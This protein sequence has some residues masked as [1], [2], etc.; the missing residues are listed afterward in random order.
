MPGT[1]AELEGVN[2]LLRAL[3]RAGGPGARK[4]MLKSLVEGAK[5]VRSAIRA[6]APVAARDTVG[7]YAHKRGNSC[8]NDD[9][10]RRLR[11]GPAQGFP[12]LGDRDGLEDRAS[13]IVRPIPFLA[14]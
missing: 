12:S 7:R 1:Y 8:C 2:E 10:R 5:Q 4:V 6:E 3:E 14:S 11:G 13:Q 9:W